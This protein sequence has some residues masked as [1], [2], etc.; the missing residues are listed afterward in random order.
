MRLTRPGRHPGPLLAS[1]LAYV[2][3]TL[4][5]GREVMASLATAIA[6]DAGDPLFTAA[7]LAWNATHVPWTDAWFQFPI[8]HPMREALILSEHLLGASLFASPVYWATG[9]PIT[10]YNVTLLLSYPLCG[11]AMYA[12][13]WRLTKSAPAAFLAGSPMRSPRIGP[14]TCR[15]FRC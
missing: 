1:A 10:A 5:M 11:L 13:V 2:A 9:N 12:L 6:S 14:V 15:T 8:F 4:V 3:V 7:I